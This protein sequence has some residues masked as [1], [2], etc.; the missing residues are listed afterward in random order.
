MVDSKALA[1]AAAIHDTRRHSDGY[2]RD[3]GER[4]ARWV[5]VHRDRLPAHCD[6]DQVAYL[7]RWHVPPDRAAPLMTDALKLFK[8]AD[9][10]D[11]WRVGG[12]SP[13]MLRTRAAH[14]LLGPS[15]RLFESTA[16]LEDG[17]AIL[18]TAVKHGFIAP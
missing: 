13:K 11:R 7:C 15:R 16:Q 2:D 3:H 1:W 9:A 8:D 17:A 10:L 14:R 6:L 4:A 18:Q 12:P 5:T